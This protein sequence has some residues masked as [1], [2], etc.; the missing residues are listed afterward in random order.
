MTKQDYL[1]NEEMEQLVHWSTVYSAA[2]EHIDSRRAAFDAMYAHYSFLRDD[3]YLVEDGTLSNTHNM[4]YRIYKPTTSTPKEGW[5]IVFYL[6]GGGFECGGLDAY[7]FLTG[8]MARSLD[9]WIF[10]VD[11]RLAPEHQ[12]PAAFEDALEGWNYLIEH[13]SLW[14][15]NPNKIVLAGDEVGALLATSLASMISKEEIQPAGIALLSP[16]LSLT[17]SFPSHEDHAKAPMINP[18]DI[19]FY[20]ERYVPEA[21]KDVLKENSPLLAKNISKVPKVWIG[22]IPWS[23]LLDEGV[24]YFELLQKEGVDVT[25]Y[26]AQSIIHNSICMWRDCPN[27]YQFYLNFLQAIR[28]MWA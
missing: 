9:A 24:A 2:D 3:S 1:L 19:S 15:I 17:E 25:L 11:Y 8:D 26:E 18:S 10:C 16:C 23:P 5:P 20:Y 7:E 22:V 21:L 6:H 12:Y 28:S 27:V 14:N 13:L 4:K